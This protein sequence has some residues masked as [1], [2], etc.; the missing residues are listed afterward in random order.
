MITDHQ[1]KE[2]DKEDLSLPAYVKETK[3]GK[4]FDP[5]TH[6]AK[7]I[8]KSVIRIGDVEQETKRKKTKVP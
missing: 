8:K 3:Y 4:E 7:E 5:V 2:F 6:I 1:V